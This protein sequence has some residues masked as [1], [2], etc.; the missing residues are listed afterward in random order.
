M[1][2]LGIPPGGV[3]VTLINKESDHYSNYNAELIAPEKLVD[4][5]LLV[6]C[7]V[8]LMN[9][10]IG[11]WAQNTT[12]PTGIDL[13]CCCNEHLLETLILLTLSA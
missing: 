5:N 11:Q 12:L 6:V 2:S 1:S 3:A 9:K 13:S 8:F 7:G 10:K 4:C